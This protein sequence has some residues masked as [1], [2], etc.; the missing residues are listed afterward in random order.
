MYDE[1]VIFCLEVPC[2]EDLVLND[3]VP[4]VRAGS[5]KERCWRW[6]SRKFSYVG[7]CSFVL[8]LGTLSKRVS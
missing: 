5:F 8:K 1:N 3:L 6:W 4:S 2:E 7:S